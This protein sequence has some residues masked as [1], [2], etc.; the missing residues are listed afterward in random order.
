M[1]AAQKLDPT[2][3]LS[4]DWLNFFELLESNVFKK[5]A[6]EADFQKKIL[7][8]L[9]PVRATLDPILIGI[10]HGLL[11]HSSIS[12][13]RLLC[14]VFV[15]QAHNNDYYKSFAAQTMHL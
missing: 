2:I 10:I 14:V 6:F 13:A 5:L 1:D 15:F 7:V 8:S 9:K 4:L 12:P 11:Y 3:T